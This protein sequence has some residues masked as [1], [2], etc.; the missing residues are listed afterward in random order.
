MS[1]PRRWCTAGHQLCEPPG[2]LAVAD[3][4]DV[5]DQGVVPDVHDVLVVPGHGYAP[6]DRG[7][8]DRDV[9]QAA[10]YDPERLVAPG[11]GEDRLGVLPVPLEE[12]LLETGELEEP[13]LLGEPLHRA[14]V[15]RAE[16]ALEQVALGVVGLA[17]HAVP[18]LVQA[19]VHVAVVVDRLHEPLHA[20]DVAGLGRADEVVV[21]DLEGG[22]GLDVA[23][24][25]PVDPVLRG[26]ALFLSGAGHLQA[27]LVGAGEKPSV[28]ADQ[29][30]PTRERVGV[31]RR[32]RRPEMRGVVD[33][34]DG[35]GQE[36]TA[37]HCLQVTGRRG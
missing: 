13:V 25:H 36:E 30:V 27:V 6:V 4:G 16:L 29:P 8:R 5:V 3:G 32:V 37:L 26:D 19:F 17:R 28:V 11:L 22:P 12:G 21:A 2:I 33:V 35:G 7:P 9:L 14:L 15:H 34:V 1:L 31:D 23:P 18:A 20:R 10:L 24:A